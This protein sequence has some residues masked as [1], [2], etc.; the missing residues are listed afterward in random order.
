MTQKFYVCHCVFLSL[1]ISEYLCVSLR[2]C[3]FLLM[4]VCGNLLTRSHHQNTYPSDNAGV[5]YVWTSA[6]SLFVYFNVWLSVCV[7]VCVTLCVSVCWLDLS[8]LVSYES[9]YNLDLPLYVWVCLTEWVSDCVW[10]GQSVSVTVCADPLFTIQT[11]CTIWCHFCK[12]HFFGKKHFLIVK[13][14]ICHDWL[15][16]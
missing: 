5:N 4:C 10:I 3:A 14:E 16:I 1:C 7:F 2:L 11:P 13:L 15:I 8:I 12:K 6:L 9:D